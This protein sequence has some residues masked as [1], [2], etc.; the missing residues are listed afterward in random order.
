MTNAGPKHFTILADE[1]W[2]RRRPHQW[3]RLPTYADCGSLLAAKLAA[4]E[5]LDD[6]TDEP[7]R[8]CASCDPTTGPRQDGHRRTSLRREA[9]HGHRFCSKE[10]VVE[11]N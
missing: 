1:I 6:E 10:Q 4:E 7:I 11:A 8:G 5:F 3:D 2:Q 9:E